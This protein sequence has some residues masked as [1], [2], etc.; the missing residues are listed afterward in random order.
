MESFVFKFAVEQRQLQ[1]LRVLCYLFVVGMSAIVCTQMLDAHS[2]LPFQAAQC[3]TVGCDRDTWNGINGEPC[4]RN[5]LKS[6]GSLHGVD[7]D[8][9]FRIKAHYTFFTLHSRIRIFCQLARGLRHVF[10]KGRH[11]CVQ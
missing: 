7:C 3:S 2:L 8:N 5:C 10:Y 4:C 1:I 11:V 9:K 6:G